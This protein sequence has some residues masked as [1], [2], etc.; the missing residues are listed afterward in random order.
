MKNIFLVREEGQEQVTK[1]MRTASGAEKRLKEHARLIH[2][3]RTRVL[4]FMKNVTK[5][6]SENNE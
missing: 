2:A 5:T 3:E 6:E 4:A 1:V